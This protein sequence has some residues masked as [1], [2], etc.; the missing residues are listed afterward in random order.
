MNGHPNSAAIKI[1]VGLSSLI[2]TTHKIGLK[3]ELQI[4][5]TQIIELEDSIVQLKEDLVHER[6]E[7]QLEKEKL[8]QSVV[9][10]CQDH[11]YT[12]QLSRLRHESHACGLKT[13]IS[14]PLT[15][16]DQFL[17]PD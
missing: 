1:T 6:E 11:V 7:A 2:L 15:P 5:S 10:I 13:S 14:H 17:T 12:C 3:N 16:A 4:S 8:T 9:R